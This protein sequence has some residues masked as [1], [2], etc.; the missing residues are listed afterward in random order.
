MKQSRDEMEQSRRHETGMVNL[1]GYEPSDRAILDVARNYEQAF[2]K[3]NRDVV[4]NDAVAS[5]AMREMMSTAATSACSDYFGSMVPS[6]QDT[7]KAIAKEQ[8]QIAVEIM[9]GWRR[10]YND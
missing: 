1:S 2:V 5:L 7:L 10:R 8:G 6:A 9:R 4:I 3:L